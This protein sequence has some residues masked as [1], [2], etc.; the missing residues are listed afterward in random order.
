MI[1]Y[2]DFWAPEFMPKNDSLSNQFYDGLEEDEQMLCDEVSRCM[3]R[4]VKKK[5]FYDEVCK[6]IPFDHGECQEYLIQVVKEQLLI[7]PLALETL[8]FY[9]L[10]YKKKSL[11]L[12]LFF[13]GNDAAI[14]K[15]APRIPYTRYV[16]ETLA[17]VVDVP[18]IIEMIE[19]PYLTQV[20][21]VDKAQFS[22]LYDAA[23]QSVSER[24]LKKTLGVLVSK[25][26]GDITTSPDDMFWVQIGKIKLYLGSDD[27]RQDDLSLYLD[28]LNEVYVNRIEVKIL[29]QDY[30]NVFRYGKVL[31]DRLEVACNVVRNLSKKVR[32][33]V[34]GDGHGCFS[35]A[36]RINDCLF[37]SSEPSEVG[38]VPY[39][40]GIINSRDYYNRSLDDGSTV[41]FAAN[42]RQFVNFSDWKGP[43]I[44]FD[45]KSY[46]YSDQGY[47]EIGYTSG[48]LW[49][50]GIRVEISPSDLSLDFNSKLLIDARK[51]VNKL[52]LRD[53]P[54]K[55]VVT[56]FRHGAL[57]RRLRLPHYNK[58]L[59]KP[60]KLSRGS[61][62]R[63]KEA[64][65]RVL[66]LGSDEDSVDLLRLQDFKSPNSRGIF[67]GKRNDLV[68]V[69]GHRPSKFA[70]KLYFVN[71]KQ[72]KIV[73][74]KYRTGKYPR[75][76][77][78]PCGRDY[79]LISAV[80]QIGDLI[81]VRRVSHD[82]RMKIVDLVREN[83]LNKYFLEIDN[84]FRMHDV[85]LAGLIPK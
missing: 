47:N 56:D 74:C 39:R 10:K 25:K 75:V 69:K 11:N 7:D 19:S 68:H 21:S 71:D 3:Q 50:R 20:T 63:D 16:I 5:D 60:H 64:R 30:T 6:A 34:P 32:Y 23:G 38:N 36:F 28:Y 13:L 80:Y 57:L 58:Y 29:S 1:Q 37:V 26:M 9:N 55:L 8:S 46:D 44:I 49:C 79:I 35:Y 12:F 41:L 51:Y 59:R 48:R 83:G 43:V 62:P 2:L 14:P 70:E 76:T 72:M 18:R 54:F 40:M 17:P 22:F 52:L 4:P 65:R 45:A 73:I 67:I 15:R 85:E 82:I 78:D 53:D 66:K 84:D 31:R 42:L 24:K 33:Y 27:Q 81:D 61:S 77:L